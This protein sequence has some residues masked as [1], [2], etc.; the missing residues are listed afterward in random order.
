MNNGF[1]VICIAVRW[2]IQF[3]FMNKILCNI[4]WLTQCHMKNKN[5][6]KVEHFCHQILKF[7]RYHIIR[8]KKMQDFPQFLH[9]VSA[10]V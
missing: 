6:K 2:I 7:T 1:H 10:I 9:V 3:M 4:A 8:C 5:A